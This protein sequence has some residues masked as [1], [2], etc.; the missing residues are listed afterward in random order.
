MIYRDKIKV[1]G[2]GR[3]EGAMRVLEFRRFCF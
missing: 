3:I 1:M 2:G